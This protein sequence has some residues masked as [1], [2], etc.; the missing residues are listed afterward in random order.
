MEGQF[1]ADNRLIPDKTP[2]A[3]PLGYSH[4][5]PLQSLI[6]R[7]VRFESDRAGQN[8]M[9][10]FEEADDFDIDGDEGE[11]QSQYQMSP[12]QE[13]YINEKPEAKRKAD[14]APADLPADSKAAPQDG[15]K[16]PA[17]PVGGPAEEKKA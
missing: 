15:V 10:T 8:G 13:E 6:A 2:V 11:M 17:P 16:Q 4:P 14:S 9:E 5:E 7:L 1:T 12:M 3:L